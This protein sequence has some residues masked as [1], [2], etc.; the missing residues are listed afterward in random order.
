[1]LKANHLLTSV[2]NGYFNAYGNAA[3]K[4]NHDWVIH[5][6]DYIYEYGASGERATVPEEE[7]FTLYDYRARHGL[8]SHARLLTYTRLTS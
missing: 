3:R 5:L 2:A 4:D 1:M 7:I 8:V 6:G